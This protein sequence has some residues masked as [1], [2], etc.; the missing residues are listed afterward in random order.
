MVLAIVDATD[1]EV[2]D[3][4]RQ[5]LTLARDV[6]AGAAEPLGAAAVG[7][8]VT[9]LVDTLGEYGVETVHAVEHEALD[10]YA[11]AAWAE[12]VSQCIAAFEPD[13]VVAPGGDR[14]PEVLAHVAARRE[15]PMA[16]EC[17]EVA[18]EAD[19]TYDL[20]RQRW[21]GTLLEHA[22]LDAPTKLLTVAPNEV[23]AE[24]AAG[25]A[26]VH[27]F[28]PDLDDDDLAVQ[29]SEVEVSDEEGVPLGEARVVVGG[30]RGTDGDFAT[31]EELAD[32]LPNAT[33]GSSRAAVNEGWRPHD[34]QIG[35]TG[36]KIAPELYVACG[37]SG[38][39]QHMVGCKGAEHVLAVN[40]DPEAAIVQKADWAVVADL[41][42]VVPAVTEAIDE[43][44]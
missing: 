5:A 26:T 32:R 8:A 16:A 23:S 13:A 24:K 3:E 34:D 20:T 44:S 25:E 11:P 9:D 1:G 19:G 35:Q 10:A 36:A 39:V 22:R 6:A 12:S 4:T 41:H 14:G 42:E 21:G 7:D 28:E 37:I 40:T 2:D 27:A 33:V 43:R 38:A 30:G 15:L 17:V 31:L 29:L 18:V